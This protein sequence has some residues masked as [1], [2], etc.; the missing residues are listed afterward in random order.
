MRGVQVR[1]RREIL[2]AEAG[3][4]LDGRSGWCYVCFMR[5]IS[6]HVSE[7]D[8]EAFRKAA[9]QRGEPIAHLIREAMATYRVEHL[10]RRTPLRGLEVADGA[11]EQE[12][13]P[14]RVE[15]HDE[16]ADRHVARETPTGSAP[17]ERRHE[18]DAADETAAS[19]VEGPESDAGT[20]A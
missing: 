20:A 19:H 10:E 4:C 15:I 17:S 18:T 5:P 8:Y 13:L 2:A 3:P 9:R 16:I 7:S 14:D 1:H 6:V 11:R 12:T